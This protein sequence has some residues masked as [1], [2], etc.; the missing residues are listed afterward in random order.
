MNNIGKV[1]ILGNSITRV[2]PVPEIGWY[3]DWGMAA[4]CEENDYVHILTRRIRSVHSGA[5]I[6]A[7]TIADWER[8]FWDGETDRM[9]LDE[10]REFHAGLIVMR[11]GENVD[12]G[13][14]ENRDFARHYA[15]FIQYINLAN[16]GS[17]VC[18]NSFWANHNVNRQIEQ[19]A[20]EAGYRHVDVSFLSNTVE[21]TAAG[22]FDHEG[23]AA[24]PSDRGMAAIA[25][26]I[27]RTIQ[28][29]IDERINTTDGGTRA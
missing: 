14:A 8:N 13:K 11:I 25:G 27:W 6:K 12:D 21:N 22:L 23:V 29:L 16:A 2:P 18:T 4:S 3:G 28:P 9:K 15:Q 19:V 20:R 17:V 24:H 7:I 10:A 5:Q 1:L 26:L